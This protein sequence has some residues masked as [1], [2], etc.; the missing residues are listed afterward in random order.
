MVTKKQNKKMLDAIEGKKKSYDIVEIGIVGVDSGQI[1]LCDPCYIDSDWENEEF[2]MPIPIEVS[3]GKELKISSWQDEYQKGMTFNQAR[4]KG[5]IREEYAKTKSN[6]SYN[7]CCQKTLDLGYGQL[8]YKL[9][10]AGVGVVSSTGW[11]DGSYPVYA[12]I[13]R[14]T[15]R[16][17]ELKVVFF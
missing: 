6:F 9:G 2:K 4:D 15:K 16:V 5:L 17:K 3:T 8:N 13:D 10:H 12:K 14:K 1:L 11:G 7:A